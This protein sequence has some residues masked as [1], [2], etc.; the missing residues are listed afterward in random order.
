MP[1]VPGAAEKEVDPGEEP[2]P[3]VLVL[4]PQHE[5]FDF[6]DLAVWLDL[7][8]QQAGVPENAVGGAQILG[9]KSIV[10]Q[11]KRCPGAGQIVELAARL[12]LENAAFGN[13]IEDHARCSF[14]HSGC[15]LVSLSEAANPWMTSFTSLQCFSCF[16]AASQRSTFGKA[17]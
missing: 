2:R 15:R 5:P 11:R 12:R 7:R 10:I 3:S 6:P 17:A 16:M 4:D 1:A 9:H 13:E 8:R 14:D